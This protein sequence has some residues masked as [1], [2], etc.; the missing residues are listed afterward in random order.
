MHQKH[1][2]LAGAGIRIKN[3]PGSEFLGIRIF[4]W[5]ESRDYRHG[6]RRQVKVRFVVWL[7]VREIWVWLQI[8][9]NGLWELY[10]LFGNITT[11]LINQQTQ[12]RTVSIVHGLTLHFVAMRFVWINIVCVYVKWFNEWRLSILLNS[13]YILCS[14]TPTPKTV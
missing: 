8:D 13:V 1:N 3:R 7:K 12:Y 5:L 10:E 9:G 4:P 14:G 6:R 11:N 2:V